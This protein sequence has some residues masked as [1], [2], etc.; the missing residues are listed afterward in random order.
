MAASAGSFEQISLSNFVSLCID[1]NVLSP[2]E[3]DGVFPDKNEKSRRDSTP[4]GVPPRRLTLQ[5]TTRKTG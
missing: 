1:R 2:Y 5:Q 4:K 3:R